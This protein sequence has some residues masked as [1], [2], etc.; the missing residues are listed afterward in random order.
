MIKPPSYCLYL[1]I[2]YRQ[3]TLL[4]D[5]KKSKDPVGTAVCVKGEG[6]VKAKELRL[7]PEISTSKKI[8]YLQSPDI[9]CEADTKCNDP[10]SNFLLLWAV[11]FCFVLF[12]TLCINDGTFT[13]L[14][15]G[16]NFLHDA[17]RWVLM[18]VLY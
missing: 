3:N 11:L 6:K 1:H 9:S 4:M 5:S 15:F 18:T 13:L 10:V 12:L 8:Y 17:N 16:D 14:Q 2:V 7:W